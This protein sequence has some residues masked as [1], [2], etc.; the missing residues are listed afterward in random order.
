MVGDKIVGL[1]QMKTLSAMLASAIVT[2]VLTVFSVPVS[3]T[4]V[5]IGGMLGAGLSRR[6]SDNEH[7]R[8][9]N[10]FRGMGAGD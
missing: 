6:P 4:Q 2:A 8:D 10:P 9:R 7:K 5:V 3:L 1:S